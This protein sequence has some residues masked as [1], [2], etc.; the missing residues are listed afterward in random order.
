[1]AP[2]S[3]VVRQ[4]KHAATIQL[5]TYFVAKDRTGWKKNVSE[6]LNVAFCISIKRW[7]KLSLDL[8]SFIAVFKGSFEPLNFET[9]LGWKNATYPGFPMLYNHG[10]YYKSATRLCQQ[11]AA[12]DPVMFCNFHWMKNHKIA[13]NSATT[14]AW[15]Q[16][17]ADL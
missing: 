9:F 5:M 2:A 16:I 8:F 3:A 4:Q 13:N 17:S 15:E 14:E 11:V 10:N 1:M 7:P 6:T 12:W